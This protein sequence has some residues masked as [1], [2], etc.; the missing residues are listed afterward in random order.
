MRA[1]IFLVLAT[2][3]AATACGDDDG[4]VDVDSGVP[5]DSGGNDAGGD[6]DAGDDDDAGALDAGCPDADGD[7]VCDVDDVCING[8]DDQDADGDG[9]PDACD[10]CDGED[11]ALDA[12]ADGV[13]DGCDCDASAERCV[14]NAVCAD[15]EAGVV[16]SCAEGFEG[17]GTTGCDPVD[18]GGLDIP[19]NGTLDADETTFGAIA[20]Y[21]C[22]TGFTIVGDAERTCQADGTWSG[23]EPF[24]SSVDCGVLSAPTNGSVDAPSTGFSA[25]ATYACNTGYLL[26]GEATRSCQMSGAWSGAAPTCML[27][28]CGTLPPPSEGTVMTNRTT[29]GGTA[30]YACNEGWR[31]SDPTTRTCLSSGSWSGRAPVCGPVDC[32]ALTAP[33]NGNVGAASTTFGSL[34]VYSCN[35]GFML[36]G[37]NMRECQSNGTWSGTTPSCTLEMADCGPPPPATGA[38]VSTSS[39][40]TEGSVATYTCGR[41]RRLLG[42]NRAVCTEAGTWVGAPAVCGEI[43]GCACSGSFA[44][45]ES[46]SAAVAS[47]SGAS[48]LAAGTTGRALAGG[49]GRPPLL[50]RW[51]GWTNGHTGFCTSAECG[52]CTTSRIRD[53]WYVEC[54]ELTSNRL[55]CGCGGQFS[56][57]DRVVALYDEPSSAAGI[58]QG[59]RGT[60]I[61]GSSGTLPVLIEWDGWTSGHTGFCFNANCGTCVT[62]ATNNRW[63]TACELVGRAP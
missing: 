24:C 33:T 61:A 58:R 18:C 29:L 13:P 41:G 60:V 15:G 55:T 43:M 39:G 1:R 51:S 31:T 20:R 2:F 4:S 35:D 12:D 40:T 6:D 59:D 10:L 38:S 42:G 17:E 47:P 30:T 36:V 52:A 14:A 27:V 28:E 34:A 57:G 44:V 56:P 8:P 62:S 54:S 22:G 50:V 11:D 23:T 9:V 26:V 5:T 45:G 37:S 53:S 21:G 7:G 46:V 25:T 16:C 19:E 49:S 32:G 48:G 3:V 63:Y